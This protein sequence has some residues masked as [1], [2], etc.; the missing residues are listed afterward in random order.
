MQPAPVRCVVDGKL[1]KALAD[2][3]QRFEQVDKSIST[4]ASLERKV[5]D[6][7]L[8]DLLNHIE[9]QSAQATDED[10]TELKSL[11]QF[12]DDWSKLRVNQ[13]VSQALAA[14]PTNAGPLNSHALV[15]QALRQMR[16]TAP[17][18]LGRFMAYADTL[19]WLE[20]A[21]S[22]NTPVKKSAAR[23]KAAKKRKPD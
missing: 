22:N 17:D 5:S 13:T 12:R 11:R 18:Y 15:L 19:L 4:T 21:N 10:P 6:A 1:A 23:G 8:A 2:Y 16:D 7:P 9:Q 14:G 3:R 20:Q